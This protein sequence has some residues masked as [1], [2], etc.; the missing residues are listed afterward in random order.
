MRPSTPERAATTDAP[1]E[2]TRK[3]NDSAVAVVRQLIDTFHASIMDRKHP[4][5]TETMFSWRCILEDKLEKL[6][7]WLSLMISPTASERVD[8]SLMV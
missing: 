4:H 1:N 6:L 5:A 2:I 8:Q 3:L 7:Q